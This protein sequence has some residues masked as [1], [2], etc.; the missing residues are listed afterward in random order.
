MITVVTMLTRWRQ[1]YQ[2]HTHTHVCRTHSFAE[3]LQPFQPTS[4][5]PLCAEFSREIRTILLMPTLGSGGDD[6]SYTHNTNANRTDLIFFESTPLNSLTL[7]AFRFWY[8]FFSVVSSVFVRIIVNSV[9]WQKTSILLINH[10]KINDKQ[11]SVL[12]AYLSVLPAWCDG[13]EGILYGNAHSILNWFRTLR[14]KHFAWV[15]YTIVWLG[16]SLFT[17]FYWL[18]V[19]AYVHVAI[20]NAF[21]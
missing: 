20:Q 2:A 19:F 5:N 21:K 17:S 16:I 8:I 18:C 15:Y 6:H 14:I 9:W 1:M 3:N 13:A 12:A 11:Q 7:Q 10:V 4:E